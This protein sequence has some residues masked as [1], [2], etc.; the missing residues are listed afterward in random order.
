MRV[1]IFQKVGCADA[2]A[3]SERKQAVVEVEEL[4]LGQVLV[5]KVSTLQ[6]VIA[7]LDHLVVVV[8]VTIDE[9]VVA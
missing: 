5:V 2:A 4:V 7:Q 6:Q 1:H 8:Y 9:C 3:F